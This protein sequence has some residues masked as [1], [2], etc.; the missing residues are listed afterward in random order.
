MRRIL[1]VALIVLGAWF[2]VSA[3]HSIQG[4]TT[5]YDEG[6]YTI[7]KQPTI[8]FD[9]P[10]HCTDARVELFTDTG[11]YMAFNSNA[12]NTGQIRRDLADPNPYAF[13]LDLTAPYN[14]V[15]LQNGAYHISVMYVCGGASY[16][17]PNYF[18]QY[19]DAL[20]VFPTPCHDSA[21]NTSYCVPLHRFY[22]TRTGAHFYTESEVE[23]R[24]VLGYQDFRYEG[25]TAFVMTNS[26]VDRTTVWRFYHR[27]N[28]THFYTANQNEAS[29]VLNNYWQT[30]NYEGPR[31]TAYTSQQ[32]GTAPF[33]RFYKYK[34]GVH[35]Y[36]SSYSEYQ[37]VLNNYGYEYRY[38]GISY[39]NIINQ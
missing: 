13:M 36:T 23:K 8:Y 38:E 39:Y 33:Y 18:D 12:S 1:I 14:N 4:Q 20:Y 9:V 25:I 28:G 17:D 7:S 26:G 19:I 5:L 24:I 10:S 32:A 34:Q 11:F 27:I 30:Y 35:F 6:G 15:T 16:A 2:P 22:N 3:G 21:T 29:I 37:T 31:Y